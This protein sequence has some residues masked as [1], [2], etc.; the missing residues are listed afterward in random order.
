M[1]ICLI[2]AQGFVRYLYNSLRHIRQNSWSFCI[3][4]AYRTKKLVM[5]IFS[6]SYQLFIQKILYKQDLMLSC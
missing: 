5:I 2:D 4:Y 1:E 6:F 3:L